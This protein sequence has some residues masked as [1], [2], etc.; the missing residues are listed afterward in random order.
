MPR[1]GLTMKQGRI[2]RWYRRP[3]ESFRRSEPLLQ[4]T[5]EKVAVD[6]EAAYDGVL[7][8]V[9]VS[10]GRSVPVGSPIAL[11][12]TASPA[13]AAAVAGAAVP[14]S[15]LAGPAAAGPGGLGPTG[16][17]SIAA[18]PEKVPPPDRATVR[19]SPAAK[20][21]ARELGVE[22]ALV[23]G[24]GPEGRVTEDDVRAFA[25][26]DA[27]AG[28]DETV[29]HS[30]WRAAVARNM[31]ASARTTA[32]VTLHRRVV[33]TLAASLLEDPRARRAQAGPL[34][35]VIKAVAVALAETPDMNATFTEQALVRHREINIGAA[36]ALPEG[37][38][39]PVLRRA[40]RLSLP[41][42]AAR[43]RELWARA[44]EGRLTAEDLS[45]G[46]FTVTNLG[47][48]GVE[49][50]TPII[51]LPE[52]A[53]LGVGRIAPRPVVQGDQVIP[54]LTVDLSLTFDH[55]AVDG[56]PAAAFLDKVAGLITAPPS[57]WLEPSRPG[58]AEAGEA[59]AGAW[60]V[61]LEAEG[62]AP[63]A[64][65]AR[66]R[67]TPGPD[68]EADVYDIVVVGA[69]PAGFTA[70]VTAARLGA[71]VAVVES[72]QVGGV[73]LNRG[74]IPTKAALE[75][76][77]RGASGGAGE[78]TALRQAVEDVV[79]A[80]RGGAEEALKELGVAVVR[81]TAALEAAQ[82]DRPPLVGVGERRLAGSGVILATGS[83]PVGLELPPAMVNPQG[84]VI[85][86]ED[87]LSGRPSPGRTLVVGGGPGGV[88]ASRILAL[89]GHKVTLVERLAWLLPGEDRDVG[90]LIRLSLEDLGVRVLTGIEL[91][92]LGPDHTGFDLVV[93]AVGRR[94]RLDGLGLEAGLTDER[95]FVRVDAYLRTGRPGLYA[96]GDVTGPPFWA[97]RA[98]EQG[99]AAA[100]N[101]LAGLES[102]S[103]LV[104]P[105]TG[106]PPELVPRVVFT[107]PEFGAVG[108]GP[109]AARAA[110]RDVV[111]GEAVMG[112]SS[113]ARAAGKGEGFVRIVADRASGRIVGMQAVCPGATEMITAGLVA[114]Q[115][116][117]GAEDLAFLPFAHPTYAESLG[118]AARELLRQ[119]TQP[120]P[121]C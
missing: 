15:G 63:A 35:V 61:S 96:A 108:L 9:L 1:L 42:L 75:K 30:D 49:G 110:G 88:E 54:K 98:S 80:I 29:P 41:Q 106:P 59:G 19:A 82:P 60:A 101:V 55:R 77:G 72:A 4:V 83:E 109:A 27:G 28:A 48:F 57:R 39:V 33:F 20:R 17:A 94:A 91:S 51:N 26:A 22:L 115:A 38:L 7:V 105:R 92:S 12:E 113:R 120:S 18:G 76:L 67:Q 87:L 45:G 64:R 102:F 74:C 44:R 78:P 114:L 53:I 21:L 86:V 69:G 32:P 85:F 112:A 95:G 68:A 11:V 70:A 93:L 46:T 119:L 103:T 50:F 52:V 100:L 89:A 111:V 121:T 2:T 5:T 66:L 8:E 40:D 14:S 47:P 104:R 107:D 16:P 65:A 34:D 99:R 73:C 36:L 81:G 97:H 116:G 24:T 117:L 118:D 6:V 23:P 84:R 3:G 62:P 58:E 56:A 10:E 13:P 43:R 25:S 90:E 79:A 71:K 31:A 37:L